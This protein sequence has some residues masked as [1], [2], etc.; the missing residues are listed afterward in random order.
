MAQK[1]LTNIDLNQ[2]QL[3]NA[4]LQL[5]ATNPNAGAGTDGQIVY[6]NTTNAILVH[7]GSDWRD[8]SGDI[9]GI[10]VLGDLQ[11]TYTQANGTVVTD[12]DNTTA[13]FGN[14]TIELTNTGVTAATYGSGTAIPT[15]T[16]DAQGRITSA[17][18][19]NVATTLNIS[20]D[21]GLASD[22]VSLLSDTLN[23]T[24]GTGVTT[25]I[26]DNDV[27]FAIGQDVGTTA[28]VTFS[29]VT[30]NLIGDIFASDG[31]SKVLE[32]GTD[33][34]DAT[35]TGDVTG[36]LTGNADTASAWET[37]RTVTFSGGDV[38][39][40]FTI[41]G[42]AD[43][44]GIA[45]TV[46]PDSVALGTDTTGDYVQNLVAGTGVAVSVTSGEGQTPT[47]SIGQSVETT[48]EP[49]FAGATL[50]DIQ[51]GVTADG[52][53]D[54]TAGN[55]TLDSAGGTVTVDDDLAVT[56]NTTI[57]G[58]L[59]VN[60]TTT[61]LATTNSVISD[62][63]IELAN[64][65]TGTPGND[66]GIVIERGDDDNAF[67]GFDESADKFIVGTG[68]FTGSDTGNL[69]IATGTL[70]ANIEGNV[71]GNLT[72]GN[73]Q[74]GVTGTNE[75]DT[76]S[77]NLTIDSA[78]GTV[79][80]DDNLTVNGTFTFD[81]V[82]LTAV[83]TSADAFSDDDTSVMTSAAVNDRFTRHYTL[84]IGNGTD[85]SIAVTHGLGTKNVVVEVYE[86]SSGETVMCDVTRTSDTVVTLG[87]ATAPATGT[88]PNSGSL[89]VVIIGM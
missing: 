78:G 50:G 70:V 71:T 87:F 36:A 33:G 30:A 29:S 1:F 32:A 89:Q 86:I 73:I 8:L 26:A 85:T 49:T 3:I 34:T 51:V 24:G 69:T 61:T 67:I 15:F 66:S 40:S 5:V 68:T 47:V 18:E 81:S 88:G 21:A 59:T 2:N 17:G 55:L 53:I 31:T 56:G 13:D 64:G 62:T 27:T 57:T 41:D 6:N 46:Q 82:G 84:D 75:I 74:V 25:T 4:V 7:D 11:V 44:T 16:V 48:D 60:G 39:G 43:V 9:K 23:F 19:V 77:G 10:T 20:G 76:T 12:Q 42:S 65:T 83:Q 37:G 52:E 79:T 28:N 54:T 14:I 45:L 38:T 63:L 22:G 58:D 35:F 80:V 72:A